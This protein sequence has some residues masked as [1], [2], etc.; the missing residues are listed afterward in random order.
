M[1]SHRMKKWL[2]QARR[3][4]CLR[5]VRRP[6]LAVTAVNALKARSPRAA[7]AS[8]AAD[9]ARRIDPAARIAISG[10]PR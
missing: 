2:V 9:P 5:V 1:Q 7:G 6:S 4:A 10:G 3:S 8:P